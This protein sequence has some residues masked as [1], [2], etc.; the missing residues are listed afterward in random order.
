MRMSGTTMRNIP[1][2]RCNVRKGEHSARRTLTIGDLPRVTLSLSDRCIH[3]HPGTG[4]TM[5]RRT[6]QL[7]HLWDPGGTREALTHVFLSSWAQGLITA[8]LTGL[9]CRADPP[10]PVSEVHPGSRTVSTRHHW[11]Q[12]DREAYDGNNPPSHLPTGAHLPH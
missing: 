7:S 4:V 3:S 6:Y 5:R 2:H 8:T 11:A 1:A 9:R 12:G 10:A